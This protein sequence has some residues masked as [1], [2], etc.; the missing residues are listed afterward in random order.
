M[1]VV[2]LVGH[3]NGVVS[4]A[5][6]W[7]ADCSRIG[8]RAGVHEVAKGMPSANGRTQRRQVHVYGWALVIWWML[9]RC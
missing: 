2:R 6:V 9:S 7:E 1:G 4:E 8:H 3:R 5:G